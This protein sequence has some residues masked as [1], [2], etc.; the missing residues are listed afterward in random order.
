M[1]LNRLWLQQ[2]RFSK[3]RVRFHDL[4]PDG[5]CIRVD[6]DKF[7]PGASLFV[8]CIN[9]VE[10]VRQ[11]HEIASRHDWVWE[12]RIHIEGGRWGVRFWRIL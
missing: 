2:P 12:C 7:V 4:A 8:P 1:K 5:V 9:S 3:N 6:W 11:V 10:C